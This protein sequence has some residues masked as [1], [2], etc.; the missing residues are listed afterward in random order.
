ML[1]Q[2]Q[3]QQKLLQQHPLQPGLLLQQLPVRRILERPTC[4]QLSS[5]WCCCCCYLH[6]QRRV[7]AAVAAAAAAGA[8]AQ[9]QSAARAEP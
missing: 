3:Q 6:I 9:Q 1:L 8:G 7:S 2:L 5:T 4:Q